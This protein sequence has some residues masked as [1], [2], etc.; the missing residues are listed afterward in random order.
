MDFRNDA[1]TKANRELRR[2][3]ATDRIVELRKPMGL[4]LDEDKN[5]N[6]FIKSIEQGGRADKSGKVFV[7]DY[8]RMV[9][10]TFGDDLWTC[11]NVGL[12]RVLSCIKVRNTK[13]VQLVLEAA[14]P[15]EEKKRRA[16]AFREPTAEEKVAKKLVTTFLPPPLYHRVDC[17]AMR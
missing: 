10:A 16:I 4:E 8:V 13:P 6:V 2:A 17:V 14:T 15:D 9:S 5:G 3:A 11:R 7:G 12:T 1:F